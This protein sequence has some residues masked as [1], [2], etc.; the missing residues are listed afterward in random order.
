LGKVPS[1][2]KPGE[3]VYLIS[4]QTVRWPLIKETRYPLF[5]HEIRM[6]ASLQAGALSCIVDYGSLFPHY[7][8]APGVLEKVYPLK[9]FPSDKKH[10]FAAHLNNLFKE[11]KEH[12]FH[13]SGIDFDP[14]SL[15]EITG[16]FAQPSELKKIK[17]DFYATLEQAYFRHKDVI[18]S[19]TLQSIR[20]EKVQ[21]SS[22][23]SPLPSP[24]A[25]IALSPQS[26]FP[27]P[28]VTKME[29]LFAATLAQSQGYHFLP[30]AP[31]IR[32]PEAFLSQLIHFL[33][34]NKDKKIC[35]G[36]NNIEHVAWLDRLR[37]IEN[38]YFFVDYAL[39]CANRMAFSFFQ[40]AI[41]RL[42]FQFYWVEGS[43]DDYDDLK[44]ELKESGQSLYFIEREFRP[45]LFIS[46]GCY[47]RH[48]RDQKCDS[49]PSIYKENIRQN[50]MRMRVVV[51]DCITYVFKAT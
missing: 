15:D 23:P 13:I 18:R 37:D 4:N 5:K 28:F 36:L 33:A 2:P 20:G 12:S 3:T 44:S 8:T 51:S 22:Q 24:V 7:P 9:T 42:L 40:A 26:F 47:L 21:G 17:N 50:Q 14:K 38:A 16:V 46:R 43:K 1:L 41:P 35:C 25:R 32:E 49:C 48:N 10:D 45:P 34:E 31:V 30:I 39:Y 29:G 27:I 6:K 19:Q 11:S